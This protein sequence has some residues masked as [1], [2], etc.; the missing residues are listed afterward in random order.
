MNPF[1]LSFRPAAQLGEH[2]ADWDSGTNDYQLDSNLTGSPFEATVQA[3]WRPRGREHGATVFHH[4][5]LHA[6]SVT[7]GFS[8]LNAMAA[9]N[10]LNTFFATAQLSTGTSIQV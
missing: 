8:V 3:S 10:A 6:N 2:D 1:R 7:S 5:R 9:E 4:L